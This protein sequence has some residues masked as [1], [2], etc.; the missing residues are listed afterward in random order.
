LKLGKH[1]GGNAPQEEATKYDDIE[2]PIQLWNTRLTRLCDGDV[3]PPAGLE[4]GEDA[5]RDKFAL[6]WWRMKV[7]KSFFRWFKNEFKFKTFH[8]IMASQ[9]TFWYPVKK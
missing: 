6:R 3:L 5:V 2:A 8:L 1:G 4:K 9:E 7:R